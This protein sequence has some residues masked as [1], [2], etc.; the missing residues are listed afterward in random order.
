MFF[1]LA[2]FQGLALAQTADMVVVNANIRTMNLG[3]PQ[4]KALAVAAGRILAI[5][6]N[7]QAHIGP[8]TRVINAAGAT[9]I[10]GLID[11]HGHMLGLGGQME[12]FDFRHTA[13]VAEIANTVAARAAKTPAGE[14]VIGRSWDQ[15]NWGGQFPTH[16]ALTA[17]TPNHPV[18]LTRVDGH[19]SWV[20]RKALNLAKI[21]AQTP[22]PPG[23][24]IE[25]D[26]AGNPTGI[27]IDRAQGLVS[28]IIPEA[29]KETVKRRL[30][31]AAEECARLGLTTVHDA[32]IGEKEIAAYKELIAEGKLPLRIYAMIGGEGALWQ[33]Y[34]KS[35]PE[36]G[37]FLTVR[38]IKLMADGAM[39]SRGAAFWQPY[40]DDKANSGLMML[41]QSDIERVATAAVKAGFQV[42]THAIGDKANRTVLDAYGAVLQG[43]TNKRFRIEHAQAVALP[44]YALFQKYGVIASIQSTHATSDMRWAQARLGPDRIAGAYAPQRFLKLAIPIA[45]GSDFPVEEPN[46]MLGFYAAV[47]RR[48]LQGKPEGGWRPD[49]KLTR[50]QALASWTL[51]GAHAAFE[52]KQKGSLEP[53]KVADFLFLDGDIMTI[54][55]SALP[56]VKVK[57]TV[58]GGKVRYEAK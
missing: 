41:K 9:V 46:P 18:Y 48:D 6:E 11:S 31:L 32:G 14:W 36:V 8:N 57:M 55:E 30:L 24:K 1:I 10:P 44:D 5:G 21:T 12:T 3:Q 15:T 35:G 56:K 25:H 23:G 34:L 45:N 26:A 58:V 27:L 19:A 40:S 28:R 38:S 43:A 20:N 33:R 52:E 47:T 49:Q 50:E 13:T 42:N 17:V 4:A 39:G 29:S 51:G 16:E 22:D 54:A 2:L 7:V 37:D 53:G